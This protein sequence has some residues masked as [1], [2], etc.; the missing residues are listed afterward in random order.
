LL[1]FGGHYKHLWDLQRGRGV[2]VDE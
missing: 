2:E 1:G